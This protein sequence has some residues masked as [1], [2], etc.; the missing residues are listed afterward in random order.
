MTHLGHS[1][2]A[3]EMQSPI[4]VNIYCGFAGVCRVY[5]PINML[6]LRPHRYF[7]MSI[8]HAVIHFHI[9]TAG[10]WTMSG[11]GGETS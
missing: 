6:C 5:H 10:S 3:A 2:G 1:L 4:A 8:D 9:S 11:H 7:P